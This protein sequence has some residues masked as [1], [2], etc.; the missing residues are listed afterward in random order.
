M[1]LN[2]GCGHDIKEGWVNIDGPREDLCYDDLK[3]DIHARIEDLDYPDNTVDEILMSA[4]FEHFPRHIAIVQLRKMYKWLKPG[5][6]ITILVPDFWGTVKMLRKSKS[7]KEQQFWFRHLYGPQDTAKFGI[8]Y[9]AFSVKKLKWIF[10][11]VGF[12]QYR[13]KVIRRWPNIEFVGIK[14]NRIKSDADAEKD[15]IDYIANYEYRR[16]SGIAF[17]AWMKDIGIQAEKPETPKYR[18]H[19]LY[20][21]PTLASLITKILKRIVS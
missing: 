20:K 14:D 16:E 18:T 19:E 11:I 21:R 3:A 9:D 17:G 8:H 6:F 2:L 7:M 12:N 13:Y 4:V 5:G 15:I 10:S 1:K